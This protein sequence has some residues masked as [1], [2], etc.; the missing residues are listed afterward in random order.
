MLA[1]HAI[2]EA[3][4]PKNPARDNNGATQHVLAARAAK[5]APKEVRNDFI[6]IYL[7]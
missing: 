3:L 5:T 6:I 7:E 4:T 2:W 1:N